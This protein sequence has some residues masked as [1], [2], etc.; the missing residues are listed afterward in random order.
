M[1]EGL[2][3]CI[4]NEL[5]GDANTIEYIWSGTLNK[6][7]GAD[8]VI[9]VLLY[10]SMLT[11]VLFVQENPGNFVSYVVWEEMAILVIWN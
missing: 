3:I 1:G 7:E 8:T 10:I 2:R 5:P 11:S 6:L 9:E 4:S